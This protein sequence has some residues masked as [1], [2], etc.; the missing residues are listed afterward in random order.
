MA[1]AG[2]GKMLFYFSDS[3]VVRLLSNNIGMY[4]LIFFVVVVIY[5]G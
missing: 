5:L 2:R 3:Q 1:N 4:K